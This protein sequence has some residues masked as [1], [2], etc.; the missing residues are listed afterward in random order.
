MAPS[1]AD[2]LKPERRLDSLQFSRVKRRGNFRQ[3]LGLLRRHAKAGVRRHADVTA[4]GLGL[5][6]LQAGQNPMGFAQALVVLQAELDQLPAGDR[7]AIDQAQFGVRRPAVV[8]QEIVVQPAALSRATAK[9]LGTRINNSRSGASRM[10]SSISASI[11]NSFSP[12][13]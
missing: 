12:T 7:L 5:G 1:H 4:H 2:S 6:D 11:A 8:G 9:P 3:R 10:S 13:R